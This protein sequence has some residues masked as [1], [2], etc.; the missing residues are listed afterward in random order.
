MQT[1]F[2]VVLRVSFVSIGELW[3]KASYRDIYFKVLP[4]GTAQV[5]GSCWV[6]QC[7]TR[8]RRVGLL[9]GWATW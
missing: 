8:A 3:G 5:P 4:K 7:S 1:R 6:T 9:R 2:A